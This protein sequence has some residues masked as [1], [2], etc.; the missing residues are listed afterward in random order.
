[1]SSLATRPCA[2]G[3]GTASDPISDMAAR[4]RERASSTERSAG[5]PP[6]FLSRR[7]EDWSTAAGWVTGRSFGSIDPDHHVGRLDDRI[8]G[9]AFGELELVDGVVGNGRGDDYPATDVDA[10]MCRGLALLDVDDRALERIACTEFHGSILGWCRCTAFSAS[11]GY[12][13]AA[14]RA[15][16]HSTSPGRTRH[17]IRASRPGRRH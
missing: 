15:P 10:D 2:A 3:S 1:M 7:C 17:K 5:L 8:G 11:A 13:E 16:R 14:C 6:G 9:L 12:S 4:M